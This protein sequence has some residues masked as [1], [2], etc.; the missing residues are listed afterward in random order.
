[1]KNNRSS[2]EIIL[3]II[4]TTVVALVII[5]LMIKIVFF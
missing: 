2:D 1:M 4:A 5:T 3:E